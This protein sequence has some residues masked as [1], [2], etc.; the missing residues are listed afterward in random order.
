M[1]RVSKKRNN[2]KFQPHGDVN[3]LEFVNGQTLVNMA[4]D[5]RGVQGEVWVT[6]S[7]V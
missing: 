2:L 4:C 6:C 5:G 3:K 7:C 1:T